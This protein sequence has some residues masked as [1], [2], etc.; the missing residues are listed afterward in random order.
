M[1]QSALCIAIQLYLLVIF[2]RIILSW[3]TMFSPPTP[4]SAYAAIHDVFVT[5]TEPVLGPVREILPPFRIG[6]TGL[7]L[8][9]IVVV[10]V[11]QIL[12][13]VICA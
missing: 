1:L 5:L 8:S 11:G 10:I 13:R 7:D 2:I 9:P 6:G 3:V 12:A 4:G